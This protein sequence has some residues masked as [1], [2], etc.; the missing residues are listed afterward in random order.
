MR[1]SFITTNFIKTGQAF[2]VKGTDKVC[3]FD[4]TTQ[5]LCPYHLLVLHTKSNTLCMLVILQCRKMCGNELNLVNSF[6]VMLGWV[7][8]A[9]SKKWLCLLVSSADNLCNQFRSRSDLNKMSDPI[10]I[11]T[12]FHFDAHLHARFVLLQM[13]FL[14]TYTFI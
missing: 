5:L 12:V 6:S 9:L 1:N 8:P 7:E 4:T 13:R 2:Q 14:F 11:Q 3:L 10:L